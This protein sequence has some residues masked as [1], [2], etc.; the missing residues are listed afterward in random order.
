MY[1]VLTFSA[2]L[3]HRNRK[4]VMKHFISSFTALSLVLTALLLIV[5]QSGMASDNS[6][7]A[8]NAVEDVLTLSIAPYIKRN[9]STG[10]T[11]M[12]ANNRLLELRDGRYEKTIDGFDYQA[13]YRY[14]IQVRKHKE[15]CLSSEKY[16]FCRYILVKIVSKEKVAARPATPVLEVRSVVPT[17]QSHKKEVHVYLATV[18]GRTVGSPEYSMYLDTEKHGELKE[19][20]HIKVT[21][22][23]TEK[24]GSKQELLSIESIEHVPNPDRARCE[25]REG[26]RWARMGRLRLPGCV[27]Y[28]ADSGKVCTDSDQC[29]GSC[30]YSPERSGFFRKRGTCSDS[31][32]PFGCKPPT[33]EQ[34]RAGDTGVLCTD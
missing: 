16:D 15:S 33:I 21:S 27:I 31:S 34:A 7:S 4:P 29:Q 11:Y 23:H 2:F 18:N 5:P 6:T 17:D 19:G 13:G 24:N 10:Y 12:T 9:S 1:H 22:Y 14:T 26:G 32:S 30:M 20:D 28:Y 8:E 25:A 3:S